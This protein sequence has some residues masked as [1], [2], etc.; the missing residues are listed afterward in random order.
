MDSVDWGLLTNLP[1]DLAYQAAEAFTEALQ[2]R[3]KAGWIHEDVTSPNESVPAL[4]RVDRRREDVA[5]RTCLR[6]KNKQSSLETPF[7]RFNG[8]GIE[9]SAGD[10]G[11]VVAARSSRSEGQRR[12][13]LFSLSIAQRARRGSNTG[14]SCSA[15]TTTLC[16]PWPQRSP[17]RFLRSPSAS[18]PEPERA[19]IFRGR[20]FAIGRTVEGHQEGGQGTT[21][22]PCRCHRRCL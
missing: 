8:R 22:S 10:R 12:P 16:T 4:R 14:A 21:D 13:L 15:S 18:M 19:G 1:F 11:R 20:E 2:K 6:T 7:A 3:T 9:A 5:P 17:N